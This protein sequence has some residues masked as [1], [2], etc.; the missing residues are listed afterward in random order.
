MENLKNKAISIL[1]WSEKY[2]KTDMMYLAKG[3]FWAI[4]SQIVVSFSTF[5]LAIAF[6]HYVS[7]EAYGQYKFILS[8]VS[9]LSTLTLTGI[10]VG[11]LRSVSL[12]YE[13]T[14][15]YAFWQNIK[16][17]G[18]FFVGA[19][20]VSIYYFKQGNITIALSLLIA[21]CLS[22]FFYSSNLYS[23]YLSAKKDFKR[24]SIY[25]DMIGNTFPSL[26]LFATMFFTNNPF[27]LVTVYFVS[28]TL[29]GIILYLKIAK[30]YKPNKSVDPEMMSYGKHLSF[31]NILNGVANNIDQILL[32]HYF[33]AVQLAT[34]NFATALPDQIKGPMKNL[35]NMIFPKFTERSDKEIKENIVHKMLV[36]F[37]VSIILIICYILIAPFIFHTFFP[38][39]NE[40]IFYSQLFSIS[41]LYIVSIP[42][43]TYLIAK[44]KIKEQYIINISTSI[45]Q[46]VVL[47]IAIIK[48]GLVGL[49]IARIFI[50]MTITLSSIIL[51]YNI[52]KTINLEERIH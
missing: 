27:W 3:S 13:G 28:N 21:G 33:G 40:S 35:T 9:I 46:I 36:L 48:W 5:L 49:I 42:T 12:G 38:K 1:R 45:L 30:I 15:Q 24:N 10:G 19:G 52:K 4:L 31:M 20:I 8:I 23:S 32:F 16:W 39:Y 50:R 22:P 47:L 37:A 17:S 2:T 11:V 25:F 14:M 7:K 6:A 18:L 41:L 29:I 43:N 44:K 26:S 34:Y 51:Y